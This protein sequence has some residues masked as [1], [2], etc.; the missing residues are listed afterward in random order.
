MTYHTY[1]L[2]KLVEEPLGVIALQ[3]RSGI[4]P[5]T[6]DL[7]Y[8]TRAL[9]TCLN[10][11]LDK[12]VVSFTATIS[13][14]VDLMLSSW[15]KLDCYELDFNLGS[16]KPQAVRR[17]LFEPVEGLTYLMPGRLDREIAV[18]ICIR[19]E[20]ME[21]LRTDKDFAKYGQYIG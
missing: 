20:D 7:G 15:A 21:R 14:S 11:A 10:R 3:L 4:D 13:P 17:P 12:N 5:K 16:G 1:T 18:G 19:D 9:A 6:S 8:C 2:Q